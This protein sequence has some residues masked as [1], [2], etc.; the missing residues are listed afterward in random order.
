MASSEIF[1]EDGFKKLS[2][3][4][5]DLIFQF[6]RRPDGTYFVPIASKGIENIFGC[7]PEDVKESFDAIAKVLHPDDALRVIEQ[8]EESAKHLSEFHCEFR[9]CIPGK[10]VQWILSRSSPEKL[11]DGSITWYGFNANITTQRNTLENYK[12]LLKKQAAILKAIPDL[13]FEI[14]Q[15][16]TIYEYHSPVNDLLAAPPELFIGK[17]TMKLSPIPLQIF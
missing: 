11:E 1:N 12:T 6:T 3:H 4:L 10:P 5:P 17:N 15:D 9:V 8:I 13:L 2:Q 7:K 14:G 16:R